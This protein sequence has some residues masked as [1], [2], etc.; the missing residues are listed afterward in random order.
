MGPLVVGEIGGGDFGDF[1]GR[2]PDTAA[3]AAGVVIG[4]V[5]EWLREHKAEGTFRL[6]QHYLLRFLDFVGDRMVSAITADTVEAARER[7]RDAVLGN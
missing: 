4:F 5:W 7:V 6:R 1:H 2:F 3:I